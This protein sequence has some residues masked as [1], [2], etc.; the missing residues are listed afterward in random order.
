MLPHYKCSGRVDVARWS[1]GRG[2][3]RR[4]VRRVVWSVVRSEAR[5]VVR[6]VAY[7]VG[8]T[9]KRRHFAADHAP[10]ESSPHGVAR[11][12]RPPLTRHAIVQV[13]FAPVGPWPFKYEFAA[14]LHQRHG[15]DVTLRGGRAIG[16]MRW[17]TR[18]MVVYN[19]WFK[20]RDNVWFKIRA[21]MTSR[22]RAAD[23][24]APSMSASASVGAL[25]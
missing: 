18:R 17:G 15:A 3:S 22:P 25:P 8:D 1:G 5:S 13:R 10:K 4:V 7:L 20:I 11:R 2:A 12:K 16:G 6:S 21:A 14:L 23:E 19:V 9:P 24:P